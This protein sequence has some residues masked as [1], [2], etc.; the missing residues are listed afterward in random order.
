MLSTFL[1]RRF[2]TAVSQNKQHNSGLAADVKTNK[3]WEGGGREG[4]LFKGK[5]IEPQEGFNH[6]TVSF[7]L[8]E[9]AELSWL[10]WTTRKSFTSS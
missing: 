10:P 2:G 5:V 4:E 6:P 9:Y 8:E 1:N 3:D 7:V